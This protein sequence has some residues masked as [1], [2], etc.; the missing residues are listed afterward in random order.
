MNKPVL[1]CTFKKEVS[2][3]S[4]KKKA[5]LSSINELVW[6]HCQLCDLNQP[7]KKEFV[8]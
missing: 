4:L 6:T 2:T 7:V 5:Q 1:Y 3:E 8:L